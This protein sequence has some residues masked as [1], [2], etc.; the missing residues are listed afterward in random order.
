MLE[1]LLILSYLYFLG[2]YFMSFYLM[3]YNHIKKIRHLWIC[4]FG[5]YIIVGMFAVAMVFVA[6][7]H[8]QDKIEDV[9]S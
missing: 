9:I 5:W 2:F 3:G 7:K 4:F 6:G 1:Q 8:I